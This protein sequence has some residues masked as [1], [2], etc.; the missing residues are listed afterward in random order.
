MSIKSVRHLTTPNQLGPLICYS[1]IK[2][3]NM[4][5][6][7]KHGI[8]P[9]LIHSIKIYRSSSN[10]YPRAA[11]TSQNRNISMALIIKHIHHVHQ[12]RNLITFTN[13]I[14]CMVMQLSMTYLTYLIVPQHLCV[15]TCSCDS[16]KM[17]TLIIN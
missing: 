16:T 15:N 1:K 11:W 5:L 10:I 9:T 12:S 14:K 13:Q 2:H 6:T 3:T 7:S 17:Q 8:C 4:H